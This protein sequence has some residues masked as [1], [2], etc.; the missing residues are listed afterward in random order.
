VHEHD[1]I[2]DAIRKADRDFQALSDRAA[3]AES[4]RDAIKETL[5]R[6]VLASGW[7]SYRSDA[8][9]RSKFVVK[10]HTPWKITDIKRL[11][12]WR[13]LKIKL[14]VHGQEGRFAPLLDAIEHQ[15]AAGALESFRLPDGCED[16]ERSEQEREALFAEWGALLTAGTHQHLSWFVEG[17]LPTGQAKP[18]PLDPIAWNALTSRDSARRST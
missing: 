15:L 8:D 1:W 5:A 13:R 10:F 2:A 12:K 18:E 7:F 6:D 16:P 14:E 11:T 3:R 9:G 4:E 17:F